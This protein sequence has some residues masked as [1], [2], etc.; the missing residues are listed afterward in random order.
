MQ[1]R[2]ILFDLDGVLAST[3]EL[4]Y[5]SWKKV[6]SEHSIPFSRQDNEKL[7]GLTRSQSLEV[8]LG[9]NQLIEAQKK[10]IL[11]N[12]NVYFFEELATL[13]PDYILPGVQNLLL[14]AGKTGI[15]LG[16]ASASRNTKAVLDRLGLLELFEVVVDGNHIT[17]SKPAPDV[18]L[19]AAAM[20]GIHPS[21]C[22]V[23]E[24]SS[25]GVEAGLRA[26]MCVVGLGPP[27]RVGKASVIFEDLSRVHLIDL[28]DIHQQCTAS[29]NP[30]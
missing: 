8:V 6:L 21:E 29:R 20:L 27:A 24:D 4:H 2:A 28:F 25:A 16:V 3:E 13:G 23:I 12:K 26:G 17:N 11:S 7:R 1:L 9:E 15:H 10:A 5:R 18:F 19:Y 14:E 30:L 22:I